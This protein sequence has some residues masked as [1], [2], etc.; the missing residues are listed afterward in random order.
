MQKKEVRRV[1]LAERMAL[2]DG[3]FELRNAQL[4][5]HFSGLDFSD[6]KA[7]HIFL[8]ILEK[9]EPNTFLL[10]EWLELNKPHIKIIVPKADFETAMMS[11]HVYIGKENL[12]KNLFDILEPQNSGA[13][14]GEIEMVIV[15]LLAFDDAG[16]RVGYGKGFY[17]GFLQNAKAKKIGLSLNN[18]PVEISDLHRGDVPLDLCITPNGIKIFS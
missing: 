6:V 9:R 16:N 13:F 12:R 7:L 14:D 8:P 18:I 3:E 4:L 5:K 15:P 11:H 2:S 17:D 10:I 1:A